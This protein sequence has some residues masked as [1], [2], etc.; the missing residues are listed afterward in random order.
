MEQNYTETREFTCAE[1]HEYIDS[2][3]TACFQH[4]DPFEAI[5][6]FLHTSIEVSLWHFIIEIIYRGLLF[7]CTLFDFG[8]FLKARCVLL[9]GGNHTHVEIQAGTVEQN[10]L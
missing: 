9:S 4:E 10:S 6:I 3:C 7:L 5:V 1:L 8:S 2:L